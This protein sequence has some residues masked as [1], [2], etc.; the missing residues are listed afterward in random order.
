MAGQQSYQIGA[1]V[2]ASAEDPYPHH[3]IACELTHSLVTPEAYKGREHIPGML[4]QNSGG[5]PER[6]D[7]P[8][9]LRKYKALFL[10]LFSTT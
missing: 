1:S 10:Y 7:K 2:A 8:Q 9:E 3:L 4:R 6:P 5:L